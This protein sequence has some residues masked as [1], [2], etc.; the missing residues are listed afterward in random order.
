MPRGPA[1][2]RFL[3]S[4]L[5]ETS[6]RVSFA[7]GVCLIMGPPGLLVELRHS[8]AFQSLRGPEVDE[9]LEGKVVAVD[10][11]LNVYSWSLC[12]SEWRW[13]GGGG[14]GGGG[15]EKTYEIQSRISGSYFLIFRF[16]DFRFHIFIVS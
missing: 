10:G 16:V 13:W 4:S 14:G 7:H 12:P 15:G 9:L 1:Y 5:T 11:A 3:T 2:R 8:G 6:P